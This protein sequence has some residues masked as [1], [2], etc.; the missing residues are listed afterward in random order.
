M[1]L[2]QNQ[3]LFAP[4]S[5]IDEVYFLN[6]GIVSIVSDVKVGTIEAALIGKEGIVG[7]PAVLHVRSTPMRS[8]VQI[9][10]EALR[11]SARQILALAK[12][13]ARFHTSLLQYSHALMIQIAYTAA[14]NRLHRTHHRCARWL[15]SAMDR[16]GS[17]TFPLTQ[18]FMGQML[19]IRRP[20]VSE[21][22]QQLKRLKTVR[23][24]HGKVTIEDRMALENI[25]CDCYHIIRAAYH[26]HTN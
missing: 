20:Q 16:V 1:E 23:Y 22:M 19:G 2:K 4:G 15:L 9:P 18:D 5:P 12:S 7:L 17:E 8:I 14:C 3:V 10:G 26:E 21:C 13:E 11:I 25:V 6:S 24:R